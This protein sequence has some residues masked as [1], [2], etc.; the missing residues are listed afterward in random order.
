MD[1]IVTRVEQNNELQH[2]GIKGQKHGIRRYQNEDGSLTAEGRQHYGHQDLWENKQMYKRGTITKDE[3]KARKKEL[4]TMKDGTKEFMTSR[5]DREFQA[6]HEKGYKRTMAVLTGSMGALSGYMIAKSK[7]ASKG[8]AAAAAVLGASALGTLGYGAQK[9]N[10][11]VN[12]E[13]LK[14]YK[15]TKRG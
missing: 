9:Y 11:H 1:F 6:R 5:R 8:Q 2:F 4:K 14:D 3:Y 10:N 15:H 7:G 12:R 13:M